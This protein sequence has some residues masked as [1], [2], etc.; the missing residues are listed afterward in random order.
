MPKYANPLLF[1]PQ[2]GQVVK[3]YFSRDPQNEQ[4]R[5]CIVVGTNPLVIACEGLLGTDQLRTL[6][7]LLIYRKE[8]DAWTQWEPDPSWVEE[9]YT[10]HLFVSTKEEALTHRL[11][12]IREV[13]AP[14]MT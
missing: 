9:T 6:E 1:E 7:N 12:F 5:L 3:F 11:S 10:R 8:R 13:L 4:M 2:L 14:R